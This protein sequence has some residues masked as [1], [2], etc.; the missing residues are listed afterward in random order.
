MDMRVIRAMVTLAAL[1]LAGPALAQTYDYDTPPSTPS[2]P[3]PTPP[4]ATGEPPLGTP[5][6]PTTPGTHTP[7]APTAP[8]AGVCTISGPVLTP[9]NFGIAAEPCSQM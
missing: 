5:G 4:P 9:A 2:T 7:A 1:S 8:A 6:M 3:S